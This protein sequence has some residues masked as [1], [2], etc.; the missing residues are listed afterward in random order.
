MTESDANTIV[1][2]YGYKAR[3]VTLGYFIA[4]KNSRGLYG[5][6][7]ALVTTKSSIVPY[8]DDYGAQDHLAASALAGAIAAGGR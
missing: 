1:A 6:D 7:V 8:A 2:Q 4:S 5:D 3:G